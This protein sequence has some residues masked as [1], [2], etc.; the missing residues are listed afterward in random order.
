M[1]QTLAHN[2]SQ[3]LHG[4]IR[5]L[6]TRHI[7]THHEHDCMD[8]VNTAIKS[9]RTSIWSDRQIQALAAFF[10]WAGE[11]QGP[12]DGEAPMQALAVILSEIFFL[13][14]LNEVRVQYR[15]IPRNPGGKIGLGFS[16]RSRSVKHLVHIIIDPQDSSKIQGVRSNRE[17]I[18]G[19]MIHE[20]AHAFIMLYGCCRK[21]LGCKVANGAAGHGRAWFNLTANIEV[22]TRGLVQLEVNLGVFEH[23]PEYVPTADEWERYY[24]MTASFG[25]IV[26][27]WPFTSN[28]EKGLNELFKLSINQ[29]SRTLEVLRQA[30]IQHGQKA[31]LAYF[32]LTQSEQEWSSGMVDEEDARTAWRRGCSNMSHRELGD[33][34]YSRH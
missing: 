30:A 32:Q 22:V 27:S 26:C 4:H 33:I 13:G 11:W 25:P 12:E 16:R 2:G 34:V 7:L 23:E 17:A 29:D 15:E 19:T 8:L 24:D 5:S 6:R 1:Q 21:C 10:V 14:Q 9:F 20:C 28:S 31:V 18:L 3:T